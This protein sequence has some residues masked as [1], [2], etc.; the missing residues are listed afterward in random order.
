MTAIL[1]ALGAYL[2]GSIPFAILVSRAMGLADPRSYGSGNIGATNVLRSG[3]RR[4]A[5][6]TLLGD[7]AKGWVAVLLAHLL[8]APV[9]I[10]ALV[11]FFAF[12]GHVFPVWLRFRGGKGVATAGGVLIAIHWVLG[13][14]TIVSWL[15]VAVTTRY[16]SLASIVS[17]VTACVAAWYLLGVGPIFYAVVA[18]AVLLIARHHAN[19]V[20]LIRGEESRIG[21]QPRG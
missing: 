7:A 4:A 1:Y 5:F 21:T 15:V 6:L 17:A 10:V 18:M 19:I 11:A 8:G 20:K 16:S 9:E 12:L 3:N 14:T 13:V 2:L